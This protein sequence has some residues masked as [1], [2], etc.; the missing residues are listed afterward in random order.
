MTE[1]HMTFFA[2]FL[3]HLFAF[4][5]KKD[6]NRGVV[7][8]LRNILYFFTRVVVIHFYPRYECFENRGVLSVL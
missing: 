6:E 5:D 3:L 4:E 2:M 8:G 1:H 7:N